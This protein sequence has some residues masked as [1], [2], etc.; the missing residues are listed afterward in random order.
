MLMF[1][2]IEKKNAL[3][4]LVIAVVEPGNVQKRST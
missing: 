3:L 1:E 2:D 4:A